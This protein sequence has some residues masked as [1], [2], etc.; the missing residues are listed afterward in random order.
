MNLRNI[1]FYFIT[2]SNLAMKSIYDDVIAALRAGVKIVQ[3]REKSKSTKEMIEEAAKIKELCKDKA[4]FLINDRVDVALAVEA[5]GVHLGQ[6]DMPYEAARHMLGYDK[7]IGITVHNIEEA[8]AAQNLGADYVGASPVFETHSKKDAG[9]PAGLELIR[10][11]REN[12][13]LPIVAIGGIKLDNLAS[14]IEAGA[15]SATALSAVLAK[16]DVEEEVRKFIEIINAYKKR[17]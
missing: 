2:D 3:Y 15:D 10:A 5:D 7:V 6:D 12:I 9:K 4:I 8:V 14:V 17:E 11:V 16:D 1:D 13:E